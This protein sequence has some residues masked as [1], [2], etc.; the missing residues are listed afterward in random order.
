MKRINKIEMIQTEKARVTS[1]IENCNSLYH[2]NN[3]VFNYCH[4][5]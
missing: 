4:R 3:S 5:S 2:H 1:F